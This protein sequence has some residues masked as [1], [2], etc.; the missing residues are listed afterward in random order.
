M[1]RKSLKRVL[2]R[3]RSLG[4][5]G[6]RKGTSVRGGLQEPQRIEGH[7]APVRVRP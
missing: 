7:P 5:G 3:L 1:M 2:D 6:L 4:S